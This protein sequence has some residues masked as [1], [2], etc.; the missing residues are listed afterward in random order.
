[1]QT[2]PDDFVFKGGLLAAG[3]QIGNAVPILLGERLIRGLAA[4]AR[5]AR[6]GR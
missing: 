2:F 4:I 1:M 3:E 6:R 5:E